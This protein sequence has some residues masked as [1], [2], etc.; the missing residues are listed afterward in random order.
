MTQMIDKLMPR[1]VFSAAI[2]GMIGLMTVSCGK[3]EYESNKDERLAIHSGNKNVEGAKY[4][5]ALADYDRALAANPSSEPAM[6]NKAMAHIYN[7]KSDT[8][9][10]KTARQMLD[11]LAKAS[12]N[13]S[14]SEKALFN[15]A[16]EQVYLGDALKAAGGD[17]TKEA[18]TNA[19]KS[20]IELYKKLLRKNPSNLKALQNLRVAQLKLPPEDQNKNQN[21]QQQQQQQ[22]Q[23]QPQPQAQPQPVNQNDQQVLQSMQNKEN[24]TRKKQPAQPS[25]QYSTDKPW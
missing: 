6:F 9:A 1:T 23:P 20:S 21:Q 4:T 16:D 5:E 12:Q 18:W 2:A 8:T 22:P 19:Y 7:P 13:P 15:M 17:E 25:Q 14:I 3:E 10:I 24:Q 11:Q